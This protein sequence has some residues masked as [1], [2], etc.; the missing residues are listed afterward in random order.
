MDA[1]RENTD[2]RILIDV[3]RLGKNGGEFSGEADIVDIDEEFVRP[4]GGVRYSFS[5]RIFGAELLVKGRL[6]QDFDLVCCRCGKDFDTTVKVED[7]V[8]SVE[9]DEKTEFVDLT[10]DVREC[11]ILALP[12]FP[13]CEESCPGIVR[14][15][16]KAP[17]DRWCAL[18]GLKIE[19][20]K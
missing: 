3:A 15:P 7:F 19:E 9:T 20:K 10:N 4:F 11:I 2:E 16:E 5:V 13:V 14:E 8:V 17:D 1:T 6:E 18:D 12:S